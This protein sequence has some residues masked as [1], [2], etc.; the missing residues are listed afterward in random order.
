MNIL[1]DEGVDR[2][3]VLALRAAGHTVGYIAESHAGIRDE[4]VLALARERKALLITADK[5]FGDLVFRQAATAEGVLLL[6]LAGLAMSQKT[7][8]CVAAIQT[9][10]TE[11]SGAFSVLTDRRLR[12]RHTPLEASKGTSSL[13]GLLRQPRTISEMDDGI[14]KAVEARNQRS[15]DGGS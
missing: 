11:F 4:E 7:Q 8:L 12:I 15:K 9:H 14:A 10:G 6:R 2:P 13:L 1:A 3:I 5:D